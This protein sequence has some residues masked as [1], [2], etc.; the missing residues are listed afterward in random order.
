[1]FF[2]TTILSLRNLTTVT[3]D[4]GLYQ[5][6]IGWPSASDDAAHPTNP[7]GSPA[8]I[9]ELQFSSSRFSF[10]PGTRPIH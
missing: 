6:E 3:R 8:G 7:G 10:C 1:M 4:L 9:P 2:E 5:G